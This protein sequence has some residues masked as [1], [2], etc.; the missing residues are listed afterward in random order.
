MTITIPTWLLWTLGIVIGVPAIMLIL[1]LAWF[2]YV[3]LTSVGR[4]WK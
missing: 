4:V 3:A 2:G 1:A